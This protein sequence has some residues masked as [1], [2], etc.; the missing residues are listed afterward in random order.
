[1][2]DRVIEKFKLNAMHLLHGCLMAIILTSFVKGIILYDNIDMS[3]IGFWFYLIVIVTGLVV[4]ILLSISGSKN[5]PITNWKTW[6]YA[7]HNKALNIF[8]I[9]FV[10][11]PVLLR[12]LETTGI[13]LDIGIRFFAYWFAGLCLSIS[14]LAYKLLAPKI[15]TFKNYDEFSRKENSFVA[16]RKESEKLA[17]ELRSRSV[18]NKL[19]PFEERFLFDDL[20]ILDRIS[21]NV[22]KSEPDA[23][24]ILRERMSHSHNKKSAFVALTFILPFYIVFLLFVANLYLVGKEAGKELEGHDSVLTAILTGKPKE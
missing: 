17:D 19:L 22:V 23:F 18:N 6:S 16:F 10:L 24:L 2:L 11:S 14:I 7:V 4:G 9:A 1:M 13:E 21:D 12:T 5:G 8:L 15:F 3:G 20:A